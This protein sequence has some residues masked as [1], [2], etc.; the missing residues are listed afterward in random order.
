MSFARPFAH[1]RPIAHEEPHIA[2]GVPRWKS[3]F[4][5]LAAAA[6]VLPC[7]V[8]TCV[9]TW[10]ASFEPFG[11][12]QGIFQFV[13]WAI[14]RG[15]RDYIDVRDF[16]GP[17]VPLIHI[18]FQKLGG[19]NEHVFRW[20]DLSAFGVGAL[21]VGAVLPG[22]FGRADSAAPR[23]VTVARRVAWALASWVVLSGGY[24][25]FDWWSHAQRESFFDDL[26]LPSIAFQLC[27][28]RPG[29][30]PRERHVFLAIAGLLSALTWF[31]KPSCLVYTLGQAVVV[32]ID[33][34]L[35][36]RRGGNLAALAAGAVGA[37]VLM[38]IALI[39]Y[40]DTAAYFQSMYAVVWRL[41][42]YIWHKSIVESYLAWDNAPKIHYILATLVAGLAAIGA[43]ILPR[44][45]LVPVVLIVGGIANFVAQGKGFP[46]HL[47]SAMVGVHLF[48]VAAA[49]ALSE[50]IAYEKL[51]WRATAAVA[52]GV[53]AL[54]V[55]V[56][57]ETWLSPSMNA[58]WYPDARAGGP[59]SE[60]F[61]THFTGG[62]YF[63]WDLHRAADYLR[64]NT[65]SDSKIQ[66]YGMDPYIMFLA[67]RLS[68]TPYIYNFE[69]NV[70]SA[71]EGN[72]SAS[73]RDWLLATVREHA[74]DLAAR[75]QRDPPAAFVA[76][77]RVPYTFPVDADS[78]FAAH[79]PEAAAWLRAHYRL[80]ERFGTVRVW[81]RD[82]SVAVSNRADR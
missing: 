70:D 8:L 61:L 9:A 7:L 17:L 21:F 34:E 30:R 59:S 77:D 73:D 41:H 25:L 5:L 2:R 71:L 52:V 76:M 22:T 82:S 62:D 39:V 35:P 16:N 63:A 43:G 26:L 23:G 27:A 1:L 33:D 81:L 45:M 44:R 49:A 11:R 66:T 36:G 54:A 69:L 28:H 55:Q 53:G 24:L 79:C 56:T 48:W 37:C 46:Y 4:P 65:P 18:L 58:D 20:L 78:E 75:L 14:S 19:A 47:Q 12:D 64:A 10:R 74:L 32:V 50:R 60:R 38:A 29:A 15:Q 67:Q 72:P 40:G 31:G 80:A 51:N 42:R 3:Y 13:G 57:D 68:A 6:L